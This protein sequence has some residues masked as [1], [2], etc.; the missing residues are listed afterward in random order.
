LIGF[1]AYA[2]NVPGVSATIPTSMSRTWAGYGDV[3]NTGEVSISGI[4]VSFIQ[5][6]ITCNSS[7]SSNQEVQ[8]LAGIDGYNLSSTL[9][10]GTQV[11]CNA[12]SSKPIYSAIASGSGSISSVKVKPG[13]TI[14]AN[15]TISGGTLTYMLSNSKGKSGLNTGAAPRVGVNSAECVTSSVTAVTG[16]PLPLAKFATVRIGQ[17]YTGVPN[18]CFVSLAGGTF[19]PIGAP[20]AYGIVIRF[21]MYNS[22][23][24]SVRAVPTTLTPSLSSFEVRWVSYGP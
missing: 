8:F 3:V 6:K 23:L 5:P 21:V 22:A 13:D 20:P 2:N 14:V 18:T 7:L 24:T 10:V 1:V 16:A 12:G 9:Y 4:F 11:T 17:D 19:N 15:I